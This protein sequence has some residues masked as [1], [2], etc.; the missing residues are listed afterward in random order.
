[1]ES[2]LAPTRPRLIEYPADLSGCSSLLFHGR[3]LLY[4]C[5]HEDGSSPFIVVLG[6][7]SGQKED[8]VTKD[9]IEPVSESGRKSASDAI[10]HQVPAE[11]SGAHILF[12]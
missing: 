12:L 5:S 11:Y 10:S 9:L 2:A 3:N 1:M 6:Y 7:F 8:V 4:L